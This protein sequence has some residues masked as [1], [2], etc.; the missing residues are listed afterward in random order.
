MTTSFKRV[1]A[2]RDKLSGIAPDTVWI[3]NPENR[4]Y[5]SG[6]TAKDTQF[7]E[8]S[9][10]LLINKTDCL[11]V[12][13]SRYTLQARNQA[14]EFDIKIISQD[15]IKSFCDIV[16]EMGSETLGFEEH[17]LTC[18]HHRQISDILSKASS[19][20][21]LTPLNSLV[22]NMREV[23]DADEIRAIKASAA[24]I[25]S[26]LDKVIEKLEPG[27]TELEVALQVENRAREAGADELAFPSIVA[28]GPNSAWP[29]AVPTNRRLKRGEPVILDVGVNLN[30]YC[31]D[32][33][34]TVFLGKPG[35]DLKKIYKTVRQAQLSAIKEIK[36]GIQS[37]EPDALAR[38]IIS[39][40][41]YGK[42]FGHALGHG[43]GL[44]THERPRLAPTKPVILKE[45][46]IVT[47]EPGIYI[48]DIG[49][50]RLEEMVQVV[51]SNAKVLTLAKHFYDF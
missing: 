18:W 48:P 24:L 10:S 46:M 2:L 1:E 13:D 20:V 34:R 23:K 11:L 4:R 38:Q 50:V 40:A 12:T 47:V 21:S 15:M 26:V 51:N 27:Q 45:G 8:S 39:E 22:E 49:G 6:Y 9:G 31:S 3:I 19:P 37:D 17:Y 44:A 25:S 41:G 36:P 16:L 33:T 14:S 30:G 28:S 5:L 35:P 29:H 43:V 7:T 32:I 42:Y